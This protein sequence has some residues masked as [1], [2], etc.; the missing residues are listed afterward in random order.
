M[1]GPINTT[2]KKKS[3]S[4]IQHAK[5]LGIYGGNGILNTAITYALFVAI[6]NFIDYRVTIVLVYPVGIFI[7]YYLNRR[8]VF[9]NKG[10]LRIFVIVSILMMGTN[11]LIAWILV[12][13]LHI[14]KEISQLIAIGFVFVLGY[15]LNNRYSFSEKYSETN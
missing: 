13:G 6:S 1:D 10:R 15:I 8:I 5:K 12:A 4:L 7:S 2:L 11:V 14:L 3:T 9:K